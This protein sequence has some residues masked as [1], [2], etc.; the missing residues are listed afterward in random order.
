MDIIMTS[1][2]YKY[3]G[4]QP[5]IAYKHGLLITEEE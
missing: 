4:E 5:R 1:G 2:K 3:A